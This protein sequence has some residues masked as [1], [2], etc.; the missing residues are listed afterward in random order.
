MKISGQISGIYKSQIG[1][2]AAQFLFWE[3]INEILFAV[4][5]NI[6]RK[7]NGPPRI[8]VLNVAVPSEKEKHLKKTIKKL[9]KKKGNGKEKE[10]CGNSDWGPSQTFLCSFLGVCRPSC[11]LPF[12]NFLRAECLAT[13]LQSPPSPHLWSNVEFYVYTWR[14]EIGSC[15]NAVE[16]TSGNDPGTITLDLVAFYTYCTWRFWPSCAHPSFI[17]TIPAKNPSFRVNRRRRKKV[18]VK[19]RHTCR[20]TVRLFLC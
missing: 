10:I 8:P 6:F 15:K 16:K 19:G 17:F 5:D 11:W 12:W 4:W 7:N 14:I 9:L 3:H 1:A 18:L 13:Y 2:E 20:E